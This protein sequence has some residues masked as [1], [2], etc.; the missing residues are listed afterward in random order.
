MMGGRIQHMTIE[1]AISILRKS[2]WRI[3]VDEASKRIVL[4]P[5]FPNV[6]WL[7]LLRQEDVVEVERKDS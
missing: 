7:H 2:G 5:P 6:N 3:D 4:H 1:Q